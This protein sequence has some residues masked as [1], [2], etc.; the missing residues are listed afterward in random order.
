LIT[1]NGVVV[2]ALITGVTGQDGGYLA[3]RLIAEGAH[4]HGLVAPGDGG[5]PE[6]FP[7]LR[8]H[9]LDLTDHDGVRRLLS[10]VA[11]DEIY[12]LAA[13]SSV[14]RSWRE[15][16][17]VA[18]VNGT[19]AVRLM[20]SALALQHELGRPVRVV[21]ASSAEIF[22]D[23]AVSPQDETTPIRP[24]TP[25]GAAKAHA[26]T[27]AGTLRDRGL[28]VSALVLYNHESPR[29]PTTFVTRRITVGVARISRGEIDRLSLGNLE[30]TRDWGWAPDYVDAMVRAARAERSSDYVIASG[31]AHTVRDF[32]AA[33]FAQIGVEDCSGLVDVEDGLLRPVDARRL[34]GD[35][36]R[37]IAELGWAPTVGFADLVARMVEADLRRT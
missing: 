30:A 15:P 21:Q 28:P 4:V 10:E 37:A 31:Q 14:A 27:M 33:A 13:I 24:I 6:R 3:E 36:S 18:A 8:R 26:H 9:V 17:R 16:E 35:S 5:S 25:Y 34:V 32:V 11:P 29:R 7:G 20:Q 2:T 23:P 22:G 19:A 1:H 12:N